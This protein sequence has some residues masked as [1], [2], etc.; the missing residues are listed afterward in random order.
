MTN[1]ENPECGSQTFLLDGHK[2]V[3]RIIED[4]LIIES[5]LKHG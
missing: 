5:P 4:K 2:R 3:V 1:D